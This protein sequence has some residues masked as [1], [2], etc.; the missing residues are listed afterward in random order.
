MGR[1]LQNLVTTIGLAPLAK[2]EQ[3]DVGTFALEAAGVIAPIYPTAQSEL[4]SGGGL[5]GKIAPTIAGFLPGG[6]VIA[7]AAQY[8]QQQGLQATSSAHKSLAFQNLLRMLITLRRN[9]DFNDLRSIGLRLREF[10]QHRLRT[11]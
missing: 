1:S 3:K 2:L 11:V 7:N 9:G 6:S 8:A 10:Q 5:L 4:G